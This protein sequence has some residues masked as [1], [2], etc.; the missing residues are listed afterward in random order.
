MM[1]RTGKQTGRTPELSHSCCAPQPLSL[2]LCAFVHSSKIT[3]SLMS[4]EG[5]DPAC[6]MLLARLRQRPAEM[7][8]L[9]NSHRYCSRECQKATLETEPR[10][11]CKRK[12]TSV[13]LF[14]IRHVRG[15]MTDNRS[16]H[17]VWQSHRFAG[18][19]QMKRPG[20]RE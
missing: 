12:G 17:G 11:G 18:C 4:A 7:R 1:E 5:R 15:L 3:V 6:T 13:T 10:M 9:S 20:Q 8:I 14:N 19:W 2:T 16:K